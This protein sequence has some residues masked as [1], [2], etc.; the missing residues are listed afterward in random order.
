MR[1][2]PA[3]RRSPVPRLS[4][5]VG[6][7]FCVLNGRSERSCIHSRGKNLIK[8]MEKANLGKLQKGFSNFAY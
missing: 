8:Y 4:E 6:M 5:P 2:I 1:I 3:W 7:D